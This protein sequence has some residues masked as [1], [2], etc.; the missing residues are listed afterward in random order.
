MSTPYTAQFFSGISDG[1]RRSALRVLPLVFALHPVRSVVDV[2][3]GAG[4]W[5]NAARQLG[6]SDVVGI[7]GD[8]VN[9]EQ[10]EIPADRFVATDLSKLTPAV[11]SSLGPATQR[12]FDL[13]ISMEVAEHLPPSSANGLVDS[14]CGLAPVVLFSAALPYQGGTNHINE[15]FPSYWVTHFA[16]NGFLPIDAIRWP[17][18]DD[19]NVEW[20][21]RQNAL[22]FVSQA[23]LVT[24]GKL[25]AARALTRDGALDVIHPA[26]YQRVVDWAIK[27]ST[28]SKA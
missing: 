24:N 20:W 11:L 12:T 1:S 7:D 16:R 10:L 25:A 28:A 22:L 4:A 13:A 6:L 18:W 23:V 5:L 3:C 15:R 14:L 27:A 21:Y 19:A 26:H 17:V 2:G 8:Y 9:R